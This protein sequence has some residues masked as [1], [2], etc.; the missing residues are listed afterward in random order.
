[1]EIEKFTS[2]PASVLDELN[3]ERNE[4]K[5]HSMEEFLKLPLNKEY[6]EKNG[7]DPAKYYPNYNLGTADPAEIETEPIQPYTVKPYEKNPYDEE[8]TSN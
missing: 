8:K 7:N 3:E 4:L 1:M 5:I 2:L 6:E